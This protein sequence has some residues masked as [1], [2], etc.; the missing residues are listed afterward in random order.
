VSSTSTCR[1]QL[2]AWET[3]TTRAAALSSATSR[4]RERNAR[5]SKCGLQVALDQVGDNAWVSGCRSMARQLICVRRSPPSRRARTSEESGGE[6][7]SVLDRAARSPSSF[8]AAASTDQRGR[9]S[10]PRGPAPRPRRQV[11]LRSIRIEAA[12]VRSHGFRR[13]RRPP[14]D[15]GQLLH[16]R[17]LSLFLG[18]HG[19]D[20]QL[21]LRE[22]EEEDDRSVGPAQI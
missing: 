1:L 16:G 4:A 11:R 10:L 21:S 8:A 15:P 20:G 7:A 2:W 17:F 9:A 6:I 12:H 18:V 13:A 19:G 5:R 3:G 22:S 14:Q